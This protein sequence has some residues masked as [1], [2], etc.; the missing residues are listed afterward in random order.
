MSA[1]VPIQSRSTR[2]RNNIYSK[3]YALILCEIVDPLE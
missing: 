1:L 2:N 3:M